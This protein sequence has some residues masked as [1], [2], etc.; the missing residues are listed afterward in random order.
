MDIIDSHHPIYVIYLLK[1]QT[2][3]IH[4]IVQ[5]EKSPHLNEEFAK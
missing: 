1:D 2:E 3:E 4:I 5:F